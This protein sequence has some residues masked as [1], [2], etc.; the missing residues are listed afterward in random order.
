VVRLAIALPILAVLAVVTFYVVENIRGRRAWMKC[1]QELA[2][3]GEQLDAA[4][5]ATNAPLADGE[6]FF[7]TPLAEA[8]FRSD[9]RAGGKP[10]PVPTGRSFNSGGWQTGWQQGVPARV[11]EWQ[12]LFTIEPPRF[13][14]RRGNA[15]PR[16]RAAD[17]NAL[18]ARKVLESFA[19]HA[20]NLTELARSL[21]ERPRGRFSTDAE[22]LATGARVS[23]NNFNTVASALSLRASAQLALSNSAPAFDDVLTILRL[24]DALRGDPALVPAVVRAGLIAQAIQPV[25][26]GCAAGRWNDGQLAGFQREFSAIDI[27]GEVAQALRR[28][29][30][31]T[32]RLLDESPGR[33]FTHASMNEWNGSGNDAK[34]LGL[35]FAVAP[36]GWLNQNRAAFCTTVQDRLAHL[37]A[38][39][40]VPPPRDE[41]LPEPDEWWR[42]RPNPYNFFA[43]ISMQTTFRAGMIGLNTQHALGLVT[44][45]C[46]MER[47]RLGAGTLPETLAQLV[48]SYLDKLPTG[49][50][51]VVLERGAEGQFTLT[52]AERKDNYGFERLPDDDARR[53]RPTWC[54]PKRR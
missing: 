2:S 46:G 52:S 12:E 24:A 23:F 47:H 40:Q 38:A 36:H 50:Q 48:P 7:F 21:T 33:A 54:Y 49:G 13:A 9:R 26:E 22:G 34:F 39:M 32:L 1:K 4:N 30:T 51:A 28:H 16:E 37:D 35:L 29:R 44:V 5:V 53:N 15:T 11:A 43:M 27:A 6:N 3:H 10:L 14:G 31:L 20:T 19:P 41:P 45:G 25:W 18:S 42:R 17:T 8:W